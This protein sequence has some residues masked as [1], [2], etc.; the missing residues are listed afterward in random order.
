MR[1]LLEESLA[2]LWRTFTEVLYATDVFLANDRY[3]Q[4]P[5]IRTKVSSMCQVDPFGLTCPRN[6]RCT[7]GAYG[8]VERPTVVWSTDKPHS[9]ISSST[10]RRLSENRRYHR[11]HVTII[12][13]AN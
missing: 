7:S 3:L 5:A 1:V 4:R 2:N 13:A 10:S 12:S 6:R 8:C 11:T 9:A